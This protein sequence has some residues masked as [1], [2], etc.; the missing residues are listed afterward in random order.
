MRV[1]VKDNDK[2]NLKMVFN[3]DAP[4]IL[5]S[6]LQDRLPAIASCFSSF[7]EKYP[8]LKQAAQLK[9]NIIDYTEGALNIENSPDLSQV[10]I[11]F[12]NTVVRYQQTVQVFL[13][14][15]VKVLRETYVKLPG[16]E[17]M[18]SFAEVLKKMFTGITTMVEKAFHLMA[19]SIENVSNAVIGMIS[20]IQV[21]MPVRDVVAGAKILDE[22][23]DR[24]KA[25]PNPIVDLLKLLESPDVFL[26]KLGEA[27]KFFVDRSQ[28][29]VDIFIK[30]DVLDAI[31]AHINALYDKYLSLMKMVTEYANTA[32]DTEYINGTINYN[33]D[34]FRSVV[35]RFNAAV[36]DYLEQAPI[37]YRS[38]VN[39][40][41][42]KLE[43]II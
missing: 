14:A 9:N 40:T 39:V 31:A 42:R 13:D 34:I 19:V 32:L 29:L 1:S 38:Y 30:Y 37:E 4:D 15:A 18:T 41:G 35:N 7:A 5:L 23:K 22:I 3:M 8:L 16:S 10:S 24:L 6:G 20:K 21:T 11:L 2:M 28:D 36:T 43:I 17:E 27:F 26:E 25:M 33:L 12:R